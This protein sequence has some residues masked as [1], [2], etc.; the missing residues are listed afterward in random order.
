MIKDPGIDA[1]SVLCDNSLAGSGWTVIQ[2]CMDGIEKFDRNWKEYVDG[3]G[4]LNG[5]F[6]IGLEK[7]HLMTRTMRH[8]LYIY[9]ADQ[10]AYT[11]YA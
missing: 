9:M 4:Q 2:K 3:F 1:F 7:L 5:E 11:Q 6:F 8:E 10:F